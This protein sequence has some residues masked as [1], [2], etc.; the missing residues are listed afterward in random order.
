MK[1]LIARYTVKPGQTETVLEHLSEMGKKVRA[2]EPGCKVYK[3]HRPDGQENMLVLYEA[4]TDQMA[5][6]A[7]RETPFFKEIIEGKV[8]PLLEKREREVLELVLE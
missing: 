5:L 2:E 8:V 7:H 1:V 6:E 3:V 4:Y